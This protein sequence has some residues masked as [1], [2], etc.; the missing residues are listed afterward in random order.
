MDAIMRRQG[1]GRRMQIPCF[2]TVSDGRFALSLRV[3]SDQ[4]IEPLPHEFGLRQ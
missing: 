3:R 2:S 1:S 4:N